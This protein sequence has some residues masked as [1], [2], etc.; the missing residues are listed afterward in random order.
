MAWKE[1]GIHTRTEARTETQ[2]HSRLYGRVVHAFG[3]SGRNLAES[4][5]ALVEKW[6]KE[7]G[8]S[9]ELIVEACRR[10]I[11][12]INSPNFGYTDTILST[13]QSRGVKNLEDV[14]LLDREHFKRTRTASAQPAPPKTGKFNI[15]SQHTYNYDQ[16]EQQFEAQLLK[17]AGQ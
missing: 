16:L 1:K 2:T 15:S 6:R 13:W 7:Y 9:E 11:Q 14:Q 4:E 8:F 10:T 17:K 3:I 12:S 5:L